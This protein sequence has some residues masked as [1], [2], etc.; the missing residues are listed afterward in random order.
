MNRRRF[1]LFSASSAAAAIL[2]PGRAHA[3]VVFDP[4][5][6][7][8][9]ILSAIRALVSN[10]NEARMIA[11]QVISLANEAKNL[12]ALP[13]DIIQ[14]FSS[15]FNDLFSAVGSVDGLMQNLS[16]LQS[17]FESLYPDF[18]AIYDPISRSSMAAD[19][20]KWIKTTREMVLGASKTGAQVLQSLPSTQAQLDRLM[21]DSQGAVG[22]LQAT[23]AGNQ[24]A[25][26][27]SGNL[28]SLNAQLAT[29][30]QAHTA[31]LMQMNGAAAA[32]RN[33]MDH[34]LDGWAQPYQ[35]NPLPEN[36]FRR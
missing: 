14:E 6:F 31:Y 9:N 22:I 27:I 3:I 25:G 2:F 24:I 8:Q 18:S 19:V 17:K 10:L 20:E 30:T 23:Q 5:N 16:T 1:I 11:N 35:G 36:P 26:T 33:R 7:G 29:Y 32:A 15:Q 28:I 13:F 34:V 4:S 12:T 21:S